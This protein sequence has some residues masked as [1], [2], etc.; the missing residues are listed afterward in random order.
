MT[1]RLSLSDWL[2]EIRSR[3][4][5]MPTTMGSCVVRISYSVSGKG[6]GAGRLRL[7]R[8]RNT[9]Y[10]I[11]RVLPPRDLLRL[12]DFDHVSFLE[13]VEIIHQDPALEAGRHFADVFL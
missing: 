11:G 4:V 13:I 9:K 2:P 7:C 8:I 5:Q 6:M 1:C 3:R 12:E 10:A